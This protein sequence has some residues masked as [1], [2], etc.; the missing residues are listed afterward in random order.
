MWGVMCGG[1]IE[2]VQG[3]GSIARWAGPKQRVGLGA[4]QCSFGVCCVYVGAEGCV[5]GS[6]GRESSSLM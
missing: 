6:G 4:I 1:H 5:V 2:A 3:A